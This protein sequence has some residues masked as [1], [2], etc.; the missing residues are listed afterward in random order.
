MLAHL[1]SIAIE[2]KAFEERLAHQSHARPAH[3]VAEPA[4]VPR[5][6]DPRG[7][8][9][10]AHAQR[11]RG[12]VPRPRPLQE[13]QRQPGSRRRRRAADRRSR[14]GWS[15]CSGRA[16]RWR[17][18]AA[19]SSPSCART[20]R[21]RRRA[22]KRSRS[23]TGCSPRSPQPFIVRGTETFVS[24]SVGI[25][26]ATGEERPKSCCATPTRRCTTPRSRAEAA[27][28]VFDD[29]MRARR[30]RAARDRERAAPGA[31]AR[32]AASCSSSPSISLSDGAVHR[33]RSARALAAPGAR[34]A[35][36]GRFVAAR[37]GDRAH[38]RPRHLG[39]RG[40]VP[41]EAAPW[42]VER[43]APVRRLG[44]PLGPPARA[45]RPR[46]TVADVIDRDRRARRQSLCLEITESVLMD[47]AE[48]VIDGHRAR[49]GRSA[50]GSAIDDF[51]TGYSSLGYL[52]RF[53]VDQVKID[54]S[55]VDGLGDR[56]RRTRRS[57][58]RSSVSPTRSACRSSPKASRPRASSPSSSRS[59][60]DEAQGYFFAPPQPI[61]DL[62]GLIGR[63]RNWRPP[64][65]KLMT[66]AM[67]PGRRD[68]SER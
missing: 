51:G 58:R 9:M 6:L 55:F 65:A 66:A 23:P 39:A 44:E 19:T 21:P 37:R 35:R 3:R 15:R 1:A 26:L 61:Q 27:S 20:C 41:H 67:R 68:R 63:A 57:C 34:A 11:G 43:D 40:G 24:A 53:P 4:V 48:G 52:K 28:R 18:S 10:P 46:R 22:T 12:A 45:A 36:A 56:S 60:C 2:R 47:D 50:C 32:R 5:S 17:A 54:R 14:A 38:R 13:R 29:A 49:H 8:A 30:A 59:G 25:A 7:R 33:R 64:G 62:R 42:Q 16:T 31:G